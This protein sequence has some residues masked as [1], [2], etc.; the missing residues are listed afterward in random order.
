MNLG[1]ELLR[2][3]RELAQEAWTD[4]ERDHALMRLEQANSVLESS[5]RA[6]RETM[7]QHAWLI[8]MCGFGV[9]LLI[10]LMS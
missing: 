7:I 10:G 4:E 8:A 9:G 5:Y 2:E 3:A 6:F 1:L